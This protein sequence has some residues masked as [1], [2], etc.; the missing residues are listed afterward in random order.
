MESTFNCI[1]PASENQAA[2]EFEWFD[3]T[4]ATLED[5]ICLVE[6]GITKLRSDLFDRHQYREW[7]VSLYTDWETGHKIANVSRG[8]VRCVK[9]D[10]KKLLREVCLQI[11]QMEMEI[12]NFY[13]RL[14][15]LSRIE[16]IRYGQR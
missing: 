7:L 3:C 8:L 12:T 10:I 1:K 14:D 13:D 15:K 11:E 16:T 5:E 6:D 9:V 4:G 2:Q